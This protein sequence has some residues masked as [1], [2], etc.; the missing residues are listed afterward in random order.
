MNPTPA[1]VLRVT[2]HRPWE[3]PS[4]PWIM[5]QGW[6]NL[7]FMHWPIPVNV[8]QTLIPRPLEL[9]T[10]HGS[11]WLGITPFDLRIKPR[12]LPTISHFPELNC[13]TYVTYGGKPG[14]FFFSLDA[15]NRLAVW[16][17]RA[18]YRL[19]YFYAQMELQEKVGMVS[20]SSRR[21]HQSASFKANYRPVGEVRLASPATLEY[22]LT[23]R[24]CLYTY[25][26]GALFR[27][28]IHHVPWPLQ[29]AAGEIIENTIAAVQGIPLPET[30]PLLHFAR[31]LDV[32]VWPLRRAN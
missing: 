5:T 8:L 25:S 21:I 30:A 28:E 24:Y 27:G 9:D 20:Y 23:E 11:A 19:P 17:A 4:G 13:R 16:G 31:Q 2:A 10:C 29:H 7:L 22:W 26:H 15:G 1:D 14:V 3:L 6:Y 18:F 32:L 12:G